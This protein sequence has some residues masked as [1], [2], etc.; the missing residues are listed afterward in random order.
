MKH[1]NEYTQKIRLGEDNFLKLEEVKKLISDECD[2]SEQYLAEHCFIKLSRTT[3][4]KI[5]DIRCN[6]NLELF[7]F[8]TEWLKERGWYLQ[9]YQ[10]SSFILDPIP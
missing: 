6:E 10:F 7:H 8:L 3:S 9:L 1:S 4:L 5:N 2:N